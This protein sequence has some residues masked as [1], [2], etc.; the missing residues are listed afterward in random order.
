MGNFLNPL[1]FGFAAVLPVI[2]LMYLLRLRRQKLVISSTML[3]RR[4]LEDLQANAPFQKLRNNLLLWLQLLIALLAML[5]LTRPF[6]KLAGM[7]GQSYVVLVDTSASMKTVETQG[8]RIELARAAMSTMIDDLSRGDEMMIVAFDREARVIQSFESDKTQLHAAARRIQ[9]R[10]AATLSRGALSLARSMSEKSERDIQVVI[11]SDGAIADLDRSP[12]AMPPV[13]FVP[14]G[15]NT[16]NV[17]IVALDL[18][19]TFDRQPDTQLFATV[20]N[21]GATGIETLLECTLDGQ[22]IDAKE[23]ALEPGESRPVIYSGLRGKSGQLELRLARRDALEADNVAYGALYAPDKLQVLLVTSGNFFLENLLTLGDRRE[24]YKITPDKYD[25]LERY[26]LTVFDNFTPADLSPGAYILLNALPPI[27]GFESAE[28]AL[29]A[30]RIVDWNRIH[31]LTRYVNFET[32]SISKA[33]DVAA[34][35]WI[36]TLAEGEISPLIYAFERDQRQAVVVAFN[37]LDSDWPLRPSFPIFITNSI[38]WLTRLSF[39]GRAFSH[40]AGVPVA[41]TPQAGQSKA[42]VES[43]SGEK[44]EIDLTQG[45]TMYFA[46]TDEAGFFRIL[47]GDEEK[48]FAVNLLSAEESNIAPSEQLSMRDQ[49]VIGDRGAVRSNREIWHWLAMAAL[50]VLAV[51]W[52]VYCRRTW[53]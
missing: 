44:T 33:M 8:T 41:I 38:N 34:P 52:I 25:P 27:E 35:Q 17:G 9:A 37:I 49:E 24:V 30:P 21:F 43:P 23:I 5:A 36:H 46:H 42:V 14:I 26:D 16:D 20:Q 12:D 48:T 45:R 3:W 2:I 15:S 10:D 18:R 47:A 11:L 13:T 40:R 6:M 29:R 22:L 7:R 32:I 31:P 1:A 19:E 4:S 51:E 28:A 50:M 53:I 39:S